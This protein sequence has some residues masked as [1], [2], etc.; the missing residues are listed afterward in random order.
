MTEAD[1]GWIEW[2]GG[3]CPV[4]PETLVD[5]RLDNPPVIEGGEKAKNLDWHDRD[6]FTAITHYRRA[7]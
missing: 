2:L 5:Y 3:D 1:E 4:S 7:S 6:P